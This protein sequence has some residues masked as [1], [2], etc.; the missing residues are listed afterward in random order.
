[1]RV[2]SAVLTFV[3]IVVVSLAIAFAVVWSLPITGW[4]R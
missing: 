1:M 3:G 2:V 4:D